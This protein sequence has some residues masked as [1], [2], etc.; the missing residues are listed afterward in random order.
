MD[1]NGHRYHDTLL[2][3]ECDLARLLST[4]CTLVKLEGVYS[5]KLY[6]S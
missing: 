6:Y 4:F 5:V 2:Y 1:M 3:S